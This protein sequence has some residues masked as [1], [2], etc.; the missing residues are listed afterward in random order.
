MKWVR[1]YVEIVIIIFMLG[2]FPTTQKPQA[3]KF[4]NDLQSKAVVTNYNSIYGHEKELAGTVYGMNAQV[5]AIGKYMKIITVK[6]KEGNKFVKYDIY[7]TANCK[8]IMNEK[9]TA[10]GTL[11]PQ[12][13]ENNLPI[14]TGGIIQV[15]Q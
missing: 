6:V 5:V 2:Y 9:L 12:R 1:M 4:N 7:N 11:Y 8:F 15:W 13:D 3:E 14:I 10:Y